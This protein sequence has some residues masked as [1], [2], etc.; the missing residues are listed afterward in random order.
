MDPA[1]AGMTP[2]EGKSKIDSRESGN[3]IYFHYSW[4]PPCS[5][6]EHLSPSFFAKKNLEKL[7]CA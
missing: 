4:C 3:P 5:S 1:F 2:K 7:I 6:Y